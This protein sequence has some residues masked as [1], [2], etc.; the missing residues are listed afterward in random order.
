MIELYDKDL[1][2]LGPVDHCIKW[3]Y[4]ENLNELSTA[5]IELPAEDASVGKIDV[6]ASFARLYDGE[7]DLGFY[8]FY[9]TLKP[10]IEKL[11]G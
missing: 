3:G 6:Q 10:M 1:N 7:K 11:L 9:Q 5:T 8:R 2:F 4:K